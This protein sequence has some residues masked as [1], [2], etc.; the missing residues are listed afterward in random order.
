LYSRKD[1]E[2]LNSY[3]DAVELGRKFIEDTEAALLRVQVMQ[4][5]LVLKAPPRGGD[6]PG[7]IPD[8]LK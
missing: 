5:K 1:N 3:K 6:G 2:T 7:K 8:Y 4:K